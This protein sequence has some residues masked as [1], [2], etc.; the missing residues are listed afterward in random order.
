MSLGGVLFEGLG[1]RVHRP[2]G[3]IWFEG[4]RLLRMIV[5]FRIYRPFVSW[6]L[7]TVLEF[8]VYGLRLGA[9]GLKKLGVHG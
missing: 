5:G 6:G 1:L 4:L 2:F 9:Y 3:G 8:G 7:V